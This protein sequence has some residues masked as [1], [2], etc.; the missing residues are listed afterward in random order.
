MR[1]NWPSQPFAQ[2]TLGLVVQKFHIAFLVGCGLVRRGEQQAL[3]V[4]NKWMFIPVLTYQSFDFLNVS[5]ECNKFS[6]NSCTKLIHIYV[7]FRIYS[8]NVWYMKSINFLALK[9]Y[10]T[11]FY[12]SISSFL[13][14]PSIPNNSAWSFGLP[15]LSFSSVLYLSR[16]RLQYKSWRQLY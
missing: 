7:N 16:A 4:F 12:Q 3:H 10:K 14:D 6:H 15:G 8:D 11:V 2:L 13:N 5:M 9:K 1:N